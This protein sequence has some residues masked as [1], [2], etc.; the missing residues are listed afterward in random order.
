MKK[1]IEAENAR[2]REELSREK[3]EKK[4]LSRKLETSNRKITE[5]QKEEKKNGVRKIMLSN[6]Q[7][8]LLS[9]LLPDINILNLLSD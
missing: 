9:N 7:E 5:L 8:Q 1:N 3:K 4:S 2:L 6:E